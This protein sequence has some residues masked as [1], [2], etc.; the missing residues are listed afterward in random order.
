[1][2][3]SN[4]AAESAA[5]ENDLA[6]AMG[7]LRQRHR[8]YLKVLLGPHMESRFSALIDDRGGD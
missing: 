7:E 1:M 5:L 8:D 2:T 3:W 4:S 6:I